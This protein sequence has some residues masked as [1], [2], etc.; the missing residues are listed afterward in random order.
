MA[1]GDVSNASSKPILVAA[2]TILEWGGGGPS[3][4]LL[5]KVDYWNPFQVSRDQKAG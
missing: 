2:W 3:F 1:E 5:L 4:S